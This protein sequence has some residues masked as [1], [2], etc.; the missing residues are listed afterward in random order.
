MIAKLLLLWL[1]CASSHIVIKSAAFTRRLSP[2]QHSSAAHGIETSPNVLLR[3]IH[4]EAQDTYYGSGQ[5][6][7]I[8]TSILD[9]SPFNQHQSYGDA[10]LN[11]TGTI[12]TIRM[13]LADLIK[14]KWYLVSNYPLKPS[15][16]IV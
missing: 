5:S 6:F 1:F 14:Y 11:P 4:I 8:A 9:P 16:P 3:D 13:L 12:L 7:F 10:K 15:I 2:Q